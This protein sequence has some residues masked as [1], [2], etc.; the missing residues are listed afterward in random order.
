MRADIEDLENGEEIKLLVELDFSEKP[1]YSWNGN[2]IDIKLTGKIDRVDTK[3]GIV[4][5]ID[6]KTG[7]FDNKKLKSLDLND[8]FQN[9]SNLELQLA[10]YAFVYGRNHPTKT[11]TS[12]I[13]ALKGNK[14]ST[15]RAQLKTCLISEMI[16]IR[17]LIVSKSIIDE[18]TNEEIDLIHDESSKY[19]Q[20]CD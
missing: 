5:L 9:A 15:T 6:Y 20:I 18:M 8:S 3:N 14:S 12:W 17:L 10:F 19:C 13:V 11:I 16:F 2:T 7:T 1:K 4:R